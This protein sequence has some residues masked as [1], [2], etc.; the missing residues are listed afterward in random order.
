MK[1]N[2]KKVVG[3]ILSI[4]MILNLVACGSGNT[5]TNT[6]NS[7][8]SPTSTESEKANTAKK[9]LRVAMTSD[10]N[11]LDPMMC[12]QVNAYYVYWTI[13]ER[14]VKL[15][16]ET[17]ELEPE[18]AERWE[19]AE[20]GSTITFYLQKG[21]KWHD[22][23]DFTAKDV[24]WSIERGIEKGTSNYPGVDYVEIVDDHTVV[25]HMIAADSVF[26]D[27]QWT[28]DCAMI[29]DGSDDNFGLKPIGT[30][31]YKLEEWVS[32]DH[33]T[34]SRFDDYWGEKSENDTII[35]QIIPE[36]SSR[37]V[38]L[39]AGDVDIAPLQAADISRVS[40]N[41]NLTLLS[42][43]SITVNYLYLNNEGDY[44]DDIKV[45]Q[46]VAYAIDKQAMIEAV[47]EGEGTELKSI[48][49]MGKKGYY[50]GME[51]YTYDPVKAKELL[52]QSE[53]PNGFS[54]E[55][56]LRS[57]PLAA[58][59]IQANLADIGID[60]KINQMEAAAFNDYVG[61]GNS[62]M[63]LY[64]RSGCS[65]DSYLYWFS[66]SVSGP[67]GNKMF[68]K[69]DRV[70]ELLIQSHL[71]LDMDARNLIYKEI[72]EILSDETPIIPLYS[73]TVFVGTD[74]RINGFS[75]DNE[76]CHDFRYTYLED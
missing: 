42:T 19:I 15:N 9:V 75:P 48:V 25:V 64:S 52:A 33:I 63:F 20:D 35:F 65:A 29:P 1:K 38:A 76:S 8:G 24:K 73:A 74:K 58:Q 67:N 23:K 27:K 32:G 26:M 57:D 66:S 3:I 51:G 39:E 21:V 49:A 37:L 71:T 41:E 6:S 22:G 68:Y 72:Q 44:F 28:G 59:L 17:N 34:V 46:A 60:A 18:L 31:R 47:L 53:Y 62:D 10:V 45:R 40:A 2:L 4:I 30:G 50:D 13:F 56:S 70:D 12:W 54:C 16:V 5:G 69:N 7:S 55:L 61:N 43:P 36:A 11:S 14:L